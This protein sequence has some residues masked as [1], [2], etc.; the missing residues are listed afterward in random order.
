M[1]SR[2]RQL[3]RR[4]KDGIKKG[5]IE[6]LGISRLQN[7]SCARSSP[8]G[9]GAQLSGCAR[10]FQGSLAHGV[11]HRIL[12]TWRTAK[13]AFRPL[14]LD[15]PSLQTPPNRGPRTPGLRRTEAGPSRSCRG[16]FRSP[17]PSSKTGQAEGITEDSLLLD[18]EKLKEKRER[19]DKEI[20]QLVSEG[21]SVDELEDHISQLHEYNDIKDVGQM[22]LGKLAVIRGV[23]TKELYPEFGLDVND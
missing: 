22:L 14:A 19:L 13:A 18:I 2:F 20:S 15:P 5:V 10:S 1:R 9:G 3:P 21:Y 17:R 16:A 23:T 8:R 6:S 12:G 11:C 7:E 4:C